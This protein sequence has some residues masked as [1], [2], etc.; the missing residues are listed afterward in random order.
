MVANQQAT[1]NFQTLLKSIGQGNGG[2]SSAATATRGLDSGHATLPPYTDHL[3]GEQ[4]RS[5][6]IHDDDSVLVSTSSLTQERSMTDKEHVYPRQG[7][8]TGSETES[9]ATTLPGSAME[10]TVTCLKHIQQA[11]ETCERG[12]RSAAHVE[13]S[14]RVY[15]KPADNIVDASTQ[16][17]W[18][19][20]S[21]TPIPIVPVRSTLDTAAPPSYSTEHVNRSESTA[22]KANRPED[23]AAERQRYI[24]RAKKDLDERRRKAE[25]ESLKLFGER[26]ELK[27]LND[28][29]NKL[30]TAEDTLYNRKVGGF[31]QFPDSASNSPGQYQPKD[32]YTLSSGTQRRQQITAAL[33][34]QIDDSVGVM[35]ENINKVSQR[36]ERLDSLQDKTDNLPVSAQGFRRGANRVRAP[37][38]S[39]WQ[40]M[41]SNA[42][43]TLWQN[44]VRTRGAIS[45]V[46]A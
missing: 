20:R 15:K 46:Q 38:K 21:I 26:E 27:L 36:G 17:Q 13:L 43:D 23:V 34:A 19:V 31:T 1:Q 16:R 25:E 39:Q 10:S 40:I 35:R 30:D 22:V 24:E 11:L 28:K 4:P 5:I 45:T 29:L 3:S 44:T 32:P 6:N 18:I 2:M 7:T 12:L 33:Q 9:H 42:S 8:G 14:I 37:R 41:W